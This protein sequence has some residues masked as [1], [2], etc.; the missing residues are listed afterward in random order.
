[1]VKYNPTNATRRRKERGPRKPSFPSR[2]TTTTRR[3]NQRMQPPPPPPLPGPSTVSVN[4]AVLCNIAKSD[5]K[6]DFGG[7][8]IPALLNSTLPVIGDIPCDGV[9]EDAT[10][11]NIG[12][13]NTGTNFTIIP[14]Q[15]TAP[16]AHETIT[17]DNLDNRLGGL[18]SSELGFIVDAYTGRFRDFCIKLKD[19]S[20]RANPD[21][22]YYWLETP[23]TMYD[24][25]P[26]TTANTAA[27]TEI[28]GPHLIFASEV[29]EHNDE[30]ISHPII[31]KKYDYPIIRD[32]DALNTE[33]RQRIFYSN[34]TITQFSTK[35]NESLTVLSDNTG[36]G[37][38]INIVV[39]EKVA[40]IKQKNMDRTAFLRL[41]NTIY[42]ERINEI[43]NISLS[44]PSSELYTN[45]VTTKYRYP[46]KR[47]GDQGQ[48]LACLRSIQVKIHNSTIQKTFSHNLCFV[49]H[50]KIALASAIVYGVPAIIFCRQ[51]GNFEVFINTTYRTP[52]QLLT[53]AKIK[54]AN[55]YNLYTTKLATLARLIDNYTHLETHIYELIY[56]RISIYQ[57]L[58]ND[59]SIK[60]RPDY[61]NFMNTEYINFF[62][63]LYNYR[64]DILYYYSKTTTIKDIRG[65]P[66]IETI[67]T[68]DITTIDVHYAKIMREYS[69][70]DMQ[71]SHIRYVLNRYTTSSNAT[72]MSRVKDAPSDISTISEIREMKLFTATSDIIS[73]RS[74][75]NELADLAGIKYI[76]TYANAL[77]YYIPTPDTFLSFIN[78]FKTIINIIKLGPIFS[79]SVKALANI[80]PARI[81]T[82]ESYIDYKKTNPGYRLVEGGMKGGNTTHEIEVAKI[83]IYNN[84]LN[85]LTKYLQWLKVYAI[86]KLTYNSDKIQRSINISTINTIAHDGTQLTLSDGT[87]VPI[88]G[89]VEI[90]YSG[91]LPLPFFIDDPMKYLIDA[92]IPAKLIYNTIIEH[93]NSNNLVALRALSIRIDLLPYPPSPAPVAQIALPLRLSVATGEAPSTPP[94]RSRN[95]WPTR[96]NTYNNAYSSKFGRRSRSR[97]RNRAANIEKR[98]TSRNR[99]R[100]IPFGNGSNN[101]RPIKYDPRRDIPNRGKRYWGLNPDVAPPP[102]IYSH[103]R[104]TGNE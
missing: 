73:A 44:N 53:N 55:I 79:S 98:S 6:H 70:L 93:Y 66:S 77:Y 9:S 69:N 47:L 61:A 39:N 21:L 8:I 82:I 84:E 14:T 72:I 102:T 28:A 52:E 88:D 36:P 43:L 16:Y 42:R 104:P 99:N 81:A 17:Y 38:P 87:I 100:K 91:E 60:G 83:D 26:K 32:L 19:G 59:E 62:E 34:Y 94:R 57:N 40:E 23:E 103:G 68:G 97:S 96:R 10:L 27:G 50:D 74:A 80:L 41:Q 76:D 33:D 65:F 30:N 11:A 18:F 22:T 20:P 49:T 51:D 7:S 46:L 1:M 89:S 90:V 64:C 3:N 45:Y 37:L 101:T 5:A 4:P 56:E 29:Y 35:T 58:L 24:P 31:H 13:I 25:A 48:A 78:V 86:H 12:I 95:S 15:Y 67:N 2:P 92:H 63:D 85:A 54:Y 71:I 75:A